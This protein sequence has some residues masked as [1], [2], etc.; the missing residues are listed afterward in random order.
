MDVVLF[1]RII[2]RARES[3]VQ[4]RS[5]EREGDEEEGTNRRD[6]GSGQAAETGEEREDPDEDLDNGGHERDDVS[7][8]H[9]LGHDAVRVQPVAE[10]LAEKLVDARIIE[11]PHRHRIKPELI[12]VR[13]AV[14]DM[15]AYTPSG[16]VGDEVP[17]A[18]IPEADVVEVFE[19][20]GGFGDGGGGVEEAVGEG[21][22]GQVEG[23]RVDGDGGGVGAEE[24]EGVVEGVIFVGA[25]EGDDDEADEG[26]DGQGHGG[27]DAGEPP[28]FA[29]DGGFC[30]GDVVGGRRVDGFFG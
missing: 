12:G 9:P 7:D 26:G 17:R 27:E 25:A 19:V 18:V 11:P 1:Q 28:G 13:R 14:R 5:R 16:A 2:E 10:F 29:H 4:N 6:D 30:F 22:G 23:G 15:V 8:E 24:V 21:V 20:E 3:R